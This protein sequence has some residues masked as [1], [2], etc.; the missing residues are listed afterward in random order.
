MEA[1]FPLQSAQVAI[2]PSNVRHLQLFEDDQPTCTVA[3]LHSPGDPAQVVALY[4]HEKWWHV[5]DVLRTSSRS[6]SG[7][8]LVRSLME[9]VIMF[10][11]SQVV[12]Q[13]SQEEALFSLHPRTESCKLL[14]RD[15]QAVGFY[16][17]KHKGNLCDSWSG[18]C[19]QLSVLDT[20]LVRRSC[21]RRGFG[22]QMLEDFC[23]SFPT[24]QFLGV[25]SPL[26]PS[27]VA[28]CRRFLQQHKEHRERLYEV[29]A[30]G[31]WIQRRNIWLIIQ[32]GINKKISPT[33]GET[34]RDDTEISSEGSSEQQIKH[35]DP[36]QGGHSLSN[37]ISGTGCSPAAHAAELD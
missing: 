4:L 6:R 33:F 29:E 15:G 28:V 23:S 16:T 36:S 26:S 7:L 21:R 30:P 11:L 5:D 24:E 35:C 19:Y 2:T 27:M 8:V 37:K 1:G 32:L 17:I 34:M 20:M 18:S 31:G 22:L 10:L 25:S 13:S 3:A 12:E 9:R 14:W